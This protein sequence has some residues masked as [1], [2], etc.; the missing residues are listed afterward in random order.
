MPRALWG[1]ILRAGAEM[2]EFEP[3]NLNVLDAPFARR[4]VADF[5]ADIARSRRITLEEWEARPWHEKALEHAL[6]LLR[7]QL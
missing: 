4:K 1:R 3:T 2:Y 5:E 6:R 7:W